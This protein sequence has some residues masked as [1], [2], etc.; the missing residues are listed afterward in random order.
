MPTRDA[1]DEFNRTLVTFGN[2]PAVR[3]RRGEEIE[4]V[5]PPTEGL[6]DEDLS[7]LLGEEPA[8]GGAEGGAEPEGPPEGPSEEVP[9]E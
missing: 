3:A 8:G 6:E 9:A 1:I 5:V 7:E 4:E 2:E